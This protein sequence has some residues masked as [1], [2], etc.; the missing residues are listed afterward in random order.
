MAMHCRQLG[1]KQTKKQG[2]PNV[3]SSAAVQGSVAGRSDRA[4]MRLPSQR[5]EN[6]RATRQIFAKTAQAPWL[7]KY[8][9]RHLSFSIEQAIVDPQLELAEE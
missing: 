4:A 8:A 3:A 7:R 6:N 9:F 1:E 5:E 2:Q